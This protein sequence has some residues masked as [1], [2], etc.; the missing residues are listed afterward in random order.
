M[1]T[2]P[3]LSLA[4]AALTGL[5]V[6]VALP[7][8][9]QGTPQPRPTPDPLTL[10]TKAADL[11]ASAG[12]DELRRGPD[13][14]YQ[15]VSVTPGGGGLFYAAYE[16]TYRGLPVIGGDAVVVTDAHG[17][18][19]D[20]T[21]ATPAPI[22]VDTA[23]AVPAERAAATARAQLSTVDSSTTPALVVLSRDAQR[24]A[25]EVV[26]TGANGDTPSRLHVFVDAHTGAVLETS[27]EV[28]A[29]TGSGF[30]Y[31]SVQLDT[32]ATGGQFSMTDSKRPGISCGP[33]SPKRVFTG[34][35]DSWGNGTASDLETGCVDVLFGAAK[36][37]D[38]LRDWVGRNGINGQGRGFPGW[39]GLNQVNAFWTGS[40]AQFG[41]VTNG[42]Q[43]T[44]IDVVAH[45]YGHAIFQTT[46]GGAGSGNENGG[47]N[48]STGDIFGAVTEAYANSPDDPPDYEVGEKIT[49]FGPIRIM[50][51]PSRKNDPNCYSSSIPN[52][53]VHKAA[54]PQN[55]WFYLLAEGTSPGG[56]KPNS[57][58]CNN[59]SITGIGVQKA[60]KIFYNGLLK[61]TSGWNHKAARKATL[62]AALALFPNSCTEFNTTKA[63]WDAI[64]VT[65]APGEPTTCTATAD[66][67]LTVTPASGRVEPGQTATTTVATR[68]TQG[69]PQQ[70][71]FTA[72]GLPA[73]AKATFTPASV[74]SDASATLAVTTAADTPTGNYPI[75]ITGDGASADHT[76]QYTLTVGA[77]QGN[78]FSI[79]LNPASVTVRPGA[80]VQVSVGTQ[81]TGGVAQPV[82]LSAA[83][84]PAGTTATFEPATIESGGS[85][86]LTIATTA[87]APPGASQVVIRGDGADIDHDVL[88]SLTIEDSTPPTCDGIPAWDAAA[89]YAPDDVVSHNGH[90]WTATYWSTGAEPGD[91]RSWAVWRDDGA[92]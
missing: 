62:E 70:V 68:T 50:Y 29:G 35:D 82:A 90:K 54:G 77:S 60:A 87:E 57:P 63:A 92:C 2:R 72:T 10:A 37:W 17:K 25:Y 73:G 43:L 81:I 19:R 41:R 75:T 52:T 69:S 26:V 12:Y 71:T 24:L 48:E 3:L 16:R 74:T 49:G 30:H 18:V 53:E 36:E 22:S 61:K 78:D 31:K 39:V 14:Q 23:A 79:S 47:L 64:S 88:L 21:A 85:A 11:A 55:H 20:T 33:L 34:A 89:P 67:E 76:V 5:A 51:D 58:T 45:E 56:G 32:T 9:A 46:P 15:R 84:L 27:D 28:R 91:P 83:K 6:L 13:D 38:M 7:A 59:S 42:P 66:F 1:R 40:E 8:S 4:A 65:T 44:S 86:T 80:S